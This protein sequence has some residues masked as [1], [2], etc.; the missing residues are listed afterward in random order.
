ML[1]PRDWEN[2]VN[3][4]PKIN[5]TAWMECVRLSL[6]DAS[7]LTP[8]GDYLPGFPSEEIQRNTTSLKGEQALSP[9]YGFYS[10][11][12]KV[13]DDSNNTIQSDWNILD[14][15][16]CWG[17]ICRFFMRDVPLQN[18]HGIDVEER[19]VDICN[20][21]FNTK[22]FIKCSALPPCSIT[23]S[24][25]DL[26]TAYSVFSHLSEFAFEAWMLEFHRILK[27]GGVVAFT[28]RNETFFNY[29]AH[30]QGHKETL[31]GYSKALATMFP[32]IQASKVK[33]QNGEFVFVT[34]PSLS[35]GG[36][37]NDSFYGEAFVPEAYV[38]RTVGTLFEILDYKTIGNGYDQALF[39]LKKRSP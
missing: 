18:L 34:E 30:L 33:Y 11:I 29:C 19:F 25:L 36:S 23:E 22:N 21:L 13:M 24:S 2:I 17:R 28:T 15:G 14:F 16:S 31:S 37:M 12:T 4:F 27:N 5:L 6:T 35:G 26:I 9:A 7:V 20:E 39:V 8:H 32:D 38:R 10:D 1:S 3:L